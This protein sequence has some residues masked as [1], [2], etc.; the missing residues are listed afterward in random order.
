L[1]LSLTSGMCVGAI[2]CLMNRT[3]ILIHEHFQVLRL[4]F[5]DSVVAEVNNKMETIV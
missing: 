5:K 1:Q 2:M 3:D 4:L